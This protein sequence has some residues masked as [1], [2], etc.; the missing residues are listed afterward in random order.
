MENPKLITAEKRVWKFITPKKWY[1]VVRTSPSVPSE[2]VQWHFYSAKSNYKIYPKSFLSL[3]IGGFVI[4]KINDEENHRLQRRKLKD[5][6]DRLDT[7]ISREKDKIRENYRDLGRNDVT[8]GKI[9]FTTVKSYVDM[10]VHIENQKQLQNNS[11]QINQKQEEYR[12]L[13]ALI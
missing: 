3:L 13:L 6:Q 11:E 1:E 8:G 4:K 7:K 10:I 9:S 12:K 2:I 5:E